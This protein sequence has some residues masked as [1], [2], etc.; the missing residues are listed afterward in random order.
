MD[1]VRDVPVNRGNLILFLNSVSFFRKLPLQFKLFLPRRFLLGLQSLQ[2]G[3]PFS[4]FFLNPLSRRELVS[5][6]HAVQIELADDLDVAARDPL[7][8]W[9]CSLR[10][11]GWAEAVLRTAVGQ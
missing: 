5:F 10:H 2:L 3:S 7:P 4:L 9:A 8:V 11:L 6:D 1:L